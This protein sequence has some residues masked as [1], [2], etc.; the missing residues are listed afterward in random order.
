MFPSIGEYTK[1][2]GL[3]NERFART[4]PD[5]LKLSQIAV[6]LARLEEKEGN[7]ARAIQ[8]FELAQKGS[9]NPEALQKQI[10]ELQQRLA[11]PSVS[12]AP[13]AR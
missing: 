11:V 6:F 3:N 9:P 12:P 10:D 7:T 2:F 1:L 8:L 5:V 4:K 13:Q